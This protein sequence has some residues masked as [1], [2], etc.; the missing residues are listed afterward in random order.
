MHLCDRINLTLCPVGAVQAAVLNRFCDVLGLEVWR[1]FQ[2][3][4][5][6]GHFQDAVV[7]ASAEAL[8]GH[9][10]FEQAFAVGG[11][12]AKAVEVILIALDAGA[13]DFHL[14][15]VGIDAVDGGAESFVEHV[16]TSG[17]FPTSCK[18]REKW[19]TPAHEVLM[20]QTPTLWTGR[21]CWL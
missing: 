4:D 14:N 7:G 18:E 6:A 17:Y 8:L 19:D 3:G 21:Q 12:L 10:A 11:Q 5:S 1:V 20:C 2:V 13:V 9:G 15:D 16:A